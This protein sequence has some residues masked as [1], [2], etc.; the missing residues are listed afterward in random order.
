MK[1]S[2]NLLEKIEQLLTDTGY[3]VRYEKGN[4]KGGYCVLDHERIIVVNKFYPLE[5]KINTLI[6][7]VQSLELDTAALTPSQLTFLKQLKKETA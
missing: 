1:V 7:V 5:G 2:K 3:T 6:D 4:F